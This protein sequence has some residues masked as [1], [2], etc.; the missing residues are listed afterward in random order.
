MN[1]KESKEEYFSCK[2]SN[3]DKQIINILQDKIDYKIVVI[4]V[5]REF[6][7]GENIEVDEEGFHLLLT[8]WIELHVFTDKY[9]MSKYEREIEKIK[10]LLYGR[11]KPE[12]N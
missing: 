10:E 12:S 4:R 5:M 3:T 2:I 8:I 6:F 1:D 9:V 11:R 7:S